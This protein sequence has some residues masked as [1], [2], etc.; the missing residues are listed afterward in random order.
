MAQ[1][2]GTTR[3][4]LTPEERKLAIERAARGIEDIVSESGVAA[5]SNMAPL[6]QTIMLAKGIN[7]MREVLTDGVVKEYFMPLQGS[8]LGFVTDKD[9]DGGYSL[10]VVREV[11]IE[12]LLRGFRPV[13]N[14]LNIIAGRFYGAKAGFERIVY[15]Y[16][17]LRGFDYVLGVPRIVGEKGALLE[18]TATWEL[19]GQKQQLACLEK[20]EDGID[21]RIAVKVNAGMGPD[22][23]LGKATRKLFARVYRKLTGCSRDI[24][25]MDP[26]DYVDASASGSN[27]VVEAPQGRRMSLRG[28][29]EEAGLLDEPTNDSPPDPE[30]D[31]R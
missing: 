16:P 2:N 20:N 19:H 13:G 7:G 31:G 6:Q 24:V 29:I 22:A 3:D 26:S 18:A 11:V 30:N 9:K 23:I 12:A 28:K 1:K 5:L 4:Q 8:P 25:D 17:G 10:E 21:T 14:E 27:P 15:E